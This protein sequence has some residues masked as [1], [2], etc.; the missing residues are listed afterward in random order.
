MTIRDEIYALENAMWQAAKAHDSAAF[1]QLV[2]AD[3]VM[4]CGGGRCSGGEY[5]VLVGDYGIADYEITEYEILYH[6][7][8]H[9]QVHYIVRTIADS[10]ENA[11]LAGVFRVTSTWERQ[12]EAWRLIFNMDQRIYL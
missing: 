11:D 1:S 4:L 7:E 3:A 5:A 9:I 6:S 8:T 2:A 10:A 12:E